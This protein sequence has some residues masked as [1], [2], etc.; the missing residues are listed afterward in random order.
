MP[1]EVST[2]PSRWPQMGKI[3][4]CLVFTA[5]RLDLSSL[6]ALRHE[7]SIKVCCRR[8]RIRCTA[9]RHRMHADRFSATKPVGEGAKRTDMCYN[10]RRWDFCVTRLPIMTLLAAFRN[11]SGPHVDCQKCKS[12]AI[13]LITLKFQDQACEH[14]KA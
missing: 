7:E 9:S 12:E 8:L 5:A 14:A 3:R 2:Y 13:L 1:F 10:Q 11:R 4:Q 6:V